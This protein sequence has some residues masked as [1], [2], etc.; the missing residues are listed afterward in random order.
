M[1][2]EDTAHFR[3]ALTWPGP[4]HRYRFDRPLRL[5]ADNLAV[6]RFSS[7]VSSRGAGVDEVTTKVFLYDLAPTLSG[8]GT[9][10]SLEVEYLLW[11]DS[12]TGTLVTDPVSIQIANPRPKSASGGWGI[13]PYLAGGLV[14]SGG[15]VVVFLIV[16]LRRRRRG[17][18]EMK[19]RSPRE[20]F[21]EDLAGVRAEAGQDLKKF[22][23]GLY[24]ILAGYLGARY[25]VDTN[26]LSAEAVAAQLR[27]SGVAQP[28]TD[29]ILGWLI[30]AERE[31]FAPVAAPPGEVVRL[32]AEIRQFFESI[33]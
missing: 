12:T 29:R 31:K 3:V 30:R 23:T 8:A 11:P 1:A 7:S 27:R 15:T 2:F 17:R 14:L 10:R 5:E 21:L 33:Q 24:R 6:A 18:T 20:C 28:E 4:P 25:G 26:N 19:L 32:E 16:A 9:I 22:Q 13:M